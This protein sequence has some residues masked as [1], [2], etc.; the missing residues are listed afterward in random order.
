MLQPGCMRPGGQEPARNA[1]DVE[2]E[3]RTSANAPSTS[4]AATERCARRE[5]T[6]RDRAEPLE[7]MRAVA[8][9]ST[10]SFT[11]YAALEAAQYA[12]KAVRP[13][14]SAAD[15]PS[16]PRRRAR[17][18][19]QVFDHWRGRSATRTARGRSACAGSATTSARTGRATGGMLRPMR[20]PGSLSRAILGMGL[21]GA[22]P[23]WGAHWR[24][25][26]RSR[27]SLPARRTGASRSD[28]SPTTSAS[29]RGESA[30][31]RGARPPAC[32]ASPSSGPDPPSI[33]TVR[34]AGRTASAS[35]PA[36]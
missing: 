9:A 32:T 8:L 6:A 13:R 2:P 12:T 26:S 31:P 17:E 36:T 10:T 30:A 29:S 21:L 34:H 28:R 24:R 14:A 27:R 20:A 35:R 11:R 5:L 23:A 19:E 18:E 4:T 16:S 22:Y 25:R 3:R 15:P 1:T 33:R 7:R